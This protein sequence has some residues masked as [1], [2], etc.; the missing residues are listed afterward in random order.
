M[1]A[2]R[3]PTLAVAHRAGNTVAGLRSALDAGA[4]LVEADV[5]LHRGLLEVRHHKTLGP[6]HLWDKWEIVSRAAVGRVELADLLAEL[7]PDPRLMLDLKGIGRGL[8]PA[9]SEALRAAAPGVA[10]TVCTQHWWMLDAFGSPVRRVYSAG[11]RRGLARLR[12]R[13]TATPA[14]GVSVR[15]DLLT[16]AVVAE[17]RAR[18]DIVMTWGVDTPGALAQ[19]RTLGVDAVISKNLDLIADLVAARRT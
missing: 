8:A 5:H 19:A 9:V 12:R 11:S 14:A 16:P 13:L 10:L 3:E 15:F 6:A 18:T 17:L 1:R 4:D 7:G 2:P